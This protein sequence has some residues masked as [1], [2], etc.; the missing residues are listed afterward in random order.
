MDI[1]WP[2]VRPEVRKG[3]LVSVSVRF[4]NRFLMENGKVLD[5]GEP[6]INTEV[7]NLKQTEGSI[8]LQARSTRILLLDNVAKAKGINRLKEGLA[9]FLKD[10]PISFYFIKPN[11]VRLGLYKFVQ[12]IIHMEPVLAGNLCAWCRVP[13]QVIHWECMDHCR[14]TGSNSMSCI[15][16]EAKPVFLSLKTF[17]CLRQWY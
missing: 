5:A 1:N 17:I 16:Q 9:K 15:T 12:R 10:K 14:R 6:P 2:W 13:L 8:F 7:K 4:C 11:F 3:V